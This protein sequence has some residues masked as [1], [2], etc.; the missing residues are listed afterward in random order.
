MATCCPPPPHPPPAF[1]VIAWE[2]VP[3]FRSFLQLAMQY[4]NVSHLIDLRTAV[5]SDSPA[6][7]VHKMVVPNRG[8]WGTAGIDGL[9]IDHH[10]AMRDDGMLKEIQVASER[11]DDVVAP[12]DEIALLKVGPA[13]CA[14]VCCCVLLCA[15]SLPARQPAGSSWPLL[16]ARLLACTAAHQLSAFRAGELSV[17]TATARPTT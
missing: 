5:I 9:N 6:G 16:A 12:G 1:R 14:V 4:N 3:L 11:L 2:P 7:T 15:V 10:N 17:L 13:V 8:I